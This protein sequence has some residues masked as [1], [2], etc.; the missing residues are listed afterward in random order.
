MSYSDLFDVAISVKKGEPLSHLLV[1]LPIN[2]IKVSV[3][4]EN[5][6]QKDL[7]VL[8]VFMLLFA[9]DIA[10]FTTSPDSLQKQLKAS[11]V[12]M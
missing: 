7:H 5:L 2:Y 11:Q 1:I 4:F 6:A 8:S 12:S 10:L 9:D 3:D